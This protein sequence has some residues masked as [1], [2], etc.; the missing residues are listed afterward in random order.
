LILRVR[1]IAAGVGTIF[2]ALV[3]NKNNNE[4]TKGDAS[5][6]E[7]AA[8]LMMLLVFAYASLETMISRFDV[9]IIFR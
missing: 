7:L 3:G 6:T 9:Q 4:M 1:I 2:A 5:M 8:A